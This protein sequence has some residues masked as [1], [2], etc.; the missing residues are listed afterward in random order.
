MTPRPRATGHAPEHKVTILV[1]MLASFRQIW[2]ASFPRAASARKPARFYQNCGA[3]QMSES[4]SGRV[5][6]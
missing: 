6:E 3:R 5:S 4:A 2:L 1:T